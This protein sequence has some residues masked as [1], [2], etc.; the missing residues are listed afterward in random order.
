MAKG[1]GGGRVQ[2]LAHCANIIFG[3]TDLFSNYQLPLITMT[4]DSF[5]QC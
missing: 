3:L 4:I 1:G 5:S 2:A